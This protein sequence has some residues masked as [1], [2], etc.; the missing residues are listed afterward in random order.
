MN[1]STDDTSESTPTSVEQS[2]AERGN[3][4]GSNASNGPREHSLEQAKGNGSFD[5]A[6]DDV[7]DDSDE[8]RMA[9]D[10]GESG[11]DGGS[12]S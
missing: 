7:T 9:S 2:D 5:D 8:A 4:D 11:Q 10:A 3:L 6:S 12:M 1:R